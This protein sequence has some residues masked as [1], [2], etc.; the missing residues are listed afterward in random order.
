MVRVAGAQVVVPPASEVPIP[1]KPATDTAPPAPDTIQ[2]P[3]GRLAAPRTA[4][5]GEKYEWNREEMFASGAL[6]VADLLERI[7]AA[8]S[9]RTGW[10]ASPKLVAVNGDFGRLRILYDGLEIDDIDPRNGSVLDLARV[11]LW[12]LEHVSVEQFANE[13]IVRL[14]SWQ[15][16]RTTAYTRTDVST[17]DEDSNLYRGFY[18]KRFSGGGGIQA[19]GQQYST[20]AA[21]LGGG[22]DALSLLLRAGVARQRWSVDAFLNR[23]Q[24]T[25]VLQPTFGS[26]LSIPDFDA[27]HRLAYLRAAYGDLN[28]GPWI[29]ATASNTR[30]A[31]TSRQTTIADAMS[32]RVVSDTADT[33]TSRSQYLLSAGYSRGLLRASA[34]SRIRSFA[35]ETFHSPGARLELVRS[36]TLVVLSAERDGFRGLNRVDASFLLTPF[37]TVAV[38]GA[39]SRSSGNGSDSLIRQPGV[40]AARLEA[41]VRLLGAWLSAG[42]LSRDTALLLPPLVF[43]TAYAPQATGRRSA[44]FLTLRGRV[45]RDIGVDVVATGWNSASFYQPR[46][47]ARSEANLNTRWISRFP[48]G[49]FGLKAAVAYDYRG[50]V[51]FPV[52]G[53]LSV[54][55]A[56]GTIS[57]LLEIRILRAVV[58]YQVRNIA[59]EL[60][61]TVPGFF[62]PRAINFYGVR[63]EFWN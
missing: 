42:L 19:G 25:R 20:T 52:P 5:L 10:L 59:G 23:S 58:S 26:G 28:G 12:T 24:Q 30:L 50:A 53:R 45:Y 16:D 35:G 54:A 1:P 7:P 17:G 2:P 6:S 38:S 11:Q 31:E 47:Q 36:Q 34:H 48:S 32:R 51:A 43:D 13:L 40:T 62:M 9:F 46:F 22:G 27:S 14:R 56:S 60:Y 49:N 57:A 44:G 39:L 33:A 37:N 41:G 29:Q 55:A 61:Q 4:T 21:R 63:W 18:G 15:V 8:T 3:F